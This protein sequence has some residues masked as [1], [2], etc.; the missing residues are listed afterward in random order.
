VNN[1][2]NNNNSKEEEEVMLNTEIGLIISEF[3]ASYSVGSLFES[4]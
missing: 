2:S 1:N 3:V 4:P